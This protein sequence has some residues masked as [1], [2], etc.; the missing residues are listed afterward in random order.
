LQIENACYPK[1][2]KW[3]K[4][5]YLEHLADPAHKIFFAE[6]RNGQIVGRTFFQIDTKNPA[7]A[8]LNDLCVLPD[9]RRRGFA[10]TILQE[11]E[12]TAWEDGA[13]S[14]TLHVQASNMAAIHLYE[15][16]G[17]KFVKRKRGLY[18]N[19]EDS[20][21]YKK[22]LPPDTLASASRPRAGGVV[23]LTSKTRALQF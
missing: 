2:I 4:K 6:D 18:G 7:V 17:Y 14:V 21:E 20:F 12:R 10:R 16:A 15:S 9:F 1:G 19:G 3:K 22:S 11:A 13:R 5:R 8:Y 23:P